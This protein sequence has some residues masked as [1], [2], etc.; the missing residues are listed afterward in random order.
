MWK[1]RFDITILLTK[2]IL[3]CSS[4]LALPG[5]EE[6]SIVTSNCLGDTNRNP[7]I[8]VCPLPLHALEDGT[9]EEAI[10]VHKTCEPIVEEP[11]SPEPENTEISEILDI[12]EAFYE[13]SDEI[14]T[15]RLNVEEF[16]QNLQHFMQENM[17]LQEG[18]MSKALVAFDP[19][20]ASIPTPK[21]KNVSRL[22]TE[23]Q[24]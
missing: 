6:K 19:K 1:Q 2:R 22:R 5:P 7:P 3:F 15:I 4:R 8:D 24:V 16:T 11:T 12:E 17:E 9:P 18:D 14:P 20:L 23:H 13:D 21:L 10:I